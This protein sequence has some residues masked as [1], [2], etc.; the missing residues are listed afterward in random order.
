MPRWIPIALAAT[1]LWHAS[2]A[3]AEAALGHEVTVGLGGVYDGGYDR[4]LHYGLA[5]ELAWRAL[6]ASALLAFGDTDPRREQEWALGLGVRPWRSFRFDV[7]LHHRSFPG[8][9]FGDN[10]V[11]LRGGIEWRGFELDAGWV[12]RFPI[13]S[14][15]QIHSPFVYDRA[16]FEHFLHFRVGYQYRFANGFGLGVLAGTFSRFEIRNFDS[17]ELGLVLSYRHPRAG[18][19]RVDAGV[20]IAGFL[21]QASTLDRGFVRF[22]Y[23]RAVSPR[24]R[25][26]GGAAPRRPRG[27]P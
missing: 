16:L 25:P 20:G 26:R 4:G 9:G 14:R 3:R 19:F 22:E 17:P 23:V 13:L 15:R 2:D 21:N 18:D 6:R 7:R 5:Y 24:P 10:L 12:L 8:V 27:R 11:V 1:L